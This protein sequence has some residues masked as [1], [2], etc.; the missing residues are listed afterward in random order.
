MQHKPQTPEQR[1]EHMANCVGC[2][3]INDW[4]GDKVSWIPCYDHAERNA[5]AVQRLVQLYE[6][7]QDQHNGGLPQTEDG[8]VNLR[9]LVDDL[10]SRFQKGTLIA[11]EAR[12]TSG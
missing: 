5:Y 9:T 3:M 8:T 11:G 10:C 6:I 7:H 1:D 12:A 4:R 2:Q